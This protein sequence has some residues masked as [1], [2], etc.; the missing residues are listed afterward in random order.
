MGFFHKHDTAI[1]EAFK[2]VMEAG[3]TETESRFFERLNGIVKM[4]ETD[5]SYTMNEKLTIYGL[6]SQL[7][8]CA[9][10]ERPRFAKKLLRILS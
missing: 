4:V 10:Q 2:K 7:S 8:N 6:I 1:A 3:R 9:S 5:K